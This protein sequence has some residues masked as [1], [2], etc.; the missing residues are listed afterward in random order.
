M[1]YTQNYVSATAFIA[2]N[3]HEDAANSDAPTSLFN[4]AW[5]GSSPQAHAPTTP[6]HHDQQQPPQ[7]TY[8]TLASYGSET[9]NRAEQPP[10]PFAI[11]TG[12][13][14]KK[15][16]NQP[17]TPLLDFL[18][19]KTY[20]HLAPFECHP[21]PVVD[22]NM[23]SNQDWTE[24]KKEMTTVFPNLNLES[25]THITLIQQL[26]ERDLLHWTQDCHVPR[27]VVSMAFAFLDMVLARSIN[28]TMEFRNDI[29]LSCL[30]MATELVN[31]E[32]RNPPVKDDGENSNP[33]GQVNGEV[34]G[35]ATSVNEEV[36]SPTIV[37]EAVNSHHSQVNEGV[38]GPASVN[39]E[40]N[41]PPIVNAV[42]AN[43]SLEPRTCFEHYI[44][45]A[46]AADER[47]SPDLDLRTSMGLELQHQQ[48][49]GMT[50]PLL[51]KLLRADPRRPRAVRRSRHSQ[52][53]RTDAP[54]G[55]LPA[56]HT[57][58]LR[59]RGLLAI[60]H[61]AAAIQGQPI[62][63]YAPWPPEPVGELVISWTDE[64]IAAA[65]AEL[66][67]SAAWKEEDWGKGVME[68]EQS[69]AQPILEYAPWPPEPTGKMFTPLEE[70]GFAASLGKFVES[71]AYKADEDWDM[72]GEE[73]AATAELPAEDREDVE[74]GKEEEEAAVT[75]ALLAEDW[76]DPMDIDEG[77]G[78][79]W[80]E[81][82]L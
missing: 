17:P 39:E 25:S 1:S 63:E 21:P 53:A 66:M 15:Y 67:E 62:L 2:N 54:L 70:E 20:N 35:P 37:N 18:S 22:F 73:R 64:E 79:D 5:V 58:G 48:P 68:K 24:L 69:T 52:L 28:A 43:P 59:E 3:Q 26:K 42:V 46:A 57:D 33:H 56:G 51:P 23:A 10:Q 30:L 61:H 80:E 72:D 40:V 31:D 50:A 6:H 77:D 14:G 16:C 4:D 19:L 81:T 36:N 32:F 76:D 65:D 8:A 44:Q 9:V 29:A 78:M 34:N 71:D 82:D 55:L 60:Q 49:A 41:G 75:V 11:L 13:D 38:N 74:E 45:I 27:D 7:Q 12:P 47:K